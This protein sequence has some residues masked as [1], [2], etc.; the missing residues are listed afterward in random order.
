[1]NLLKIRKCYFAAPRRS[2]SAAHGITTLKL[3][4][5]KLPPKFAFEEALI[6]ESRIGWILLETRG[7]CQRRRQPRREGGQ[8]LQNGGD[9]RGREKFSGAKNRQCDLQVERKKA[10]TRLRDSGSGSVRWT[11]CLWWRPLTQRKLQFAKPATS[12]SIHAWP[13]LIAIAH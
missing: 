10:L 2:K 11:L 7:P 5:W 12:P 6:W 1:M 9:G 3:G 8:L 13:L 4:S